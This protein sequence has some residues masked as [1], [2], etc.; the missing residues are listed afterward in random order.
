[1]A[2]K[3]RQQAEKDIDLLQNR[4]NLLRKEEERTNK[5]IQDTQ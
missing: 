3:Q 4:I 1:M 2:K 5:K